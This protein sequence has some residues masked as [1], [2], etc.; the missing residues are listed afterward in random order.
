M[1]NVAATLLLLV[2]WYTVSVTA[3]FGPMLVASGLVASGVMLGTLVASGLVASGLVASGNSAGTLVASG[4]V[5]SGL[6]A[7]G[8]MISAFVG[9]VA[10]IGLVGSCTGGCRGG[11][12]RSGFRMIELCRPPETGLPP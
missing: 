2:I 12:D 1:L 4:L 6:V 8:V 7:S 9:S 3:S 10:S 5:A 11:V